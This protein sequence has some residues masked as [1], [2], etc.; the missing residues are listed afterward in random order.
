MEAGT[1]VA[2]S[3][4][5]RVMKLLVTRHKIKKG[6]IGRTCGTLGR[7]EKWYETVVG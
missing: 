6:V 5:L 3:Y 1:S 7:G 2:C 4:G